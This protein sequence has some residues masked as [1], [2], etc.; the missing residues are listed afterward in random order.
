MKYFV[1]IGDKEYEFEANGENGRTTLIF[2]KR[3]ISV[4]FKRIG[5]SP[6]YSLLL[7]GKSYDVWASSQN[8]S[9][10]IGIGGQSYSARVEDERQRLLKQLTRSE[11]KGEGLVSVKA[12]MPGLVVRIA[13]E[14]GISVKKGEGVMVIEAMKMENE[15]KAPISGIVKSIGVRQGDAID[16]NALLF[17]IRS[18]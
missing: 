17:E 14:E 16:K 13:V 12:P 4:D 7:D 10:Q 8:G 11:A 9:I 15:I 2:E 3:S 1:T 18:E 5:N 6:M